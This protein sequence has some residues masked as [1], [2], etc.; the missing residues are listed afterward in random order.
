M[1]RVLGLLRARN[2]IIVPLKSPDSH[3]NYTGREI[4]PNNNNDDVIIIIIIF[5]TE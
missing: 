4:M 1:L 2:E 5:F 3:N